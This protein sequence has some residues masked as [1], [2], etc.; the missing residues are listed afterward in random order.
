MSAMSELDIEVSELLHDG[1]DATDIAHIL[2]V[3]LSMVRNLVQ[4][5]EDDE[6]LN[7]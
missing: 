5:I 1:Y 7:R 4:D 2:N 3:P 6:F